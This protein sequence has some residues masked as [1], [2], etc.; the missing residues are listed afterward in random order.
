[1]QQA[2]LRPGCSEPHL[3]GIK[4]GGVT[5]QFGQIPSMPPKPMQW[6]NWKMLKGRSAFFGAKALNARV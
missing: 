2:T 4:P 3:L 6:L 1:M 5:A